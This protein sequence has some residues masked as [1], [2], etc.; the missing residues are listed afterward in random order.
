[1][2][3]LPFDQQRSN[4]TSEQHDALIS[5]SNRTDLIIKKADKGSLTVIQDRDQY[6]SECFQHLFQSNVYK[7]HFQDP[8]H[9]IYRQVVSFLFEAYLN[10]V[11][12]REQHNWAVIPRNFIKTPIFTR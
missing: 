9:D 5:L 6:V 2:M 12:T 8:S 10:H 7:V 3:N 1:M 11:I 4:L